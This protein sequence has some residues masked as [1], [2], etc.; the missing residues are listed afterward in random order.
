MARRGFVSG[1]ALLSNLEPVLPSKA[2]RVGGF[3]LQLPFS[4][5]PPLPPCPS[6]QLAIRSLLG[7]SVVGSVPY[8]SYAHHSSLTNQ[9]FP[10]PLFLSAIIID[11][12]PQQKRTL[13]KDKSRRSKSRIKIKAKARRAKKRA[14]FEGTYSSNHPPPKSPLTHFP[15]P[16]P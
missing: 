16:S 2:P 8:P 10:S 6:F 3:W 1:R 15:T 4:I 13:R 14:L 9:F 7:L 11:P 5:P 12:P